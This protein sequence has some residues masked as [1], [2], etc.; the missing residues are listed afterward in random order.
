MAD[1]SDYGPAPSNVFTLLVIIAA[2]VMIGATVFLA[3]R[4]NQ[5]FGTYS[6]F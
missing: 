2:I 1:Q 4:S 3:I 6:P 5:L